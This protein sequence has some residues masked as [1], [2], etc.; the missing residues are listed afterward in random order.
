MK[1]WK[2]FNIESKKDIFNI[3]SIIDLEKERE[4]LEEVI[5]KYLEEK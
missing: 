2:L 5:Q 3:F 1:S 4:H